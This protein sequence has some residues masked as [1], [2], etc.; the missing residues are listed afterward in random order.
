MVPP[1]PSPLPDGRGGDE[2]AGIAMCITSLGT[3]PRRLRGQGRGRQDPG[4]P[5][6]DP[7]GPASHR[8]RDPDGLAGLD[9]EEAWRIEDSVFEVETVDPTGG[10]F[11]EQNPCHRIE[12]SHGPHDLDAI[13]D[14]LAAAGGRLDSAVADRGETALAISEAQL[15][16]LRGHDPSQ[17]APHPLHQQLLPAGA[18]GRSQRGENRQR[19]QRSR[20]P[21]WR[22]APVSNPPAVPDIAAHIA[23]WAS[24][25]SRG[26]PSRRPYH[27]IAFITEQAAGLSTGIPGRS[28]CLVL[29]L[30]PERGSL[31]GQPAGTVLRLAFLRA[32][33]P[34]AADRGASC[35]FH[36]PT[37]GD[38]SASLRRDGDGGGDQ[39]LPGRLLDSDPPFEPA[40]RRRGR[41]FS[42]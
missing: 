13:A 41:A 31:G 18:S 38:R 3:S 4:S 22:P 19:D 21:D 25:A 28:S 30:A 7:G 27:H 34:S 2:G 35:S 32:R 29:P 33:I 20:P 8:S 5:S 15:A 17:G 23:A 39:P 6:L 26:P 14:P 16:F 42:P 9:V 10:I 11:G 36:R 24:E 1:H 12:R 37:G 40:S